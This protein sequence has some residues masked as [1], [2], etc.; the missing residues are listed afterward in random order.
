MY[1]NFVV[2]YIAFKKY[3]N[4]EF[5]FYYLGFIFFRR[6]VLEF[7]FGLLNYFM[8]FGMVG[9]ICR[10]KRVFCSL[11]IRVGGDFSIKWCKYF[12]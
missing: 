11:R 2:R 6:L 8:I 7:A 12:T 1:K 4:S 5:Y 3:V 9:I 10:F